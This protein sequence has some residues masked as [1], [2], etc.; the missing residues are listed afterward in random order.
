MFSKKENQWKHFK[1]PKLIFWI[2]CDKIDNIIWKTR[3]L[4][5]LLIQVDKGGKNTEAILYSLPS[6]P[7]D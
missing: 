7:Q 1:L 5:I 6:N 3:I 4:L 2:K